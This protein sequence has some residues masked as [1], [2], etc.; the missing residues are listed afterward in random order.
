MFEKIISLENL[1]LAW[2]EFRKG[3]SKKQDIADFEMNL[4]D[5]IFAL[6]KDLASGA[7]KHGKY[8]SFYVCDPKRRHIHK[9]TV[10]DR[11]L[12]R[13]VV[14]VIEPIWERTFIFDSWSCRKDKGHH[15]AIRRFQRFGR[16]LSQNYTKTLWILKLDIR[17]FF[18][19]VNRDVLLKI[20]A[21]KI[22]DERLLSLLR[23]I[24][25]S[26]S[27]GLPLG[28]LTSQ[29]FANIYLDRLDR[30][31]K[32]GL[33][34]RGYIRYADDFIIMHTD[35]DVLRQ[36]LL[37][38]QRFLSEELQ[39]NLH[40]LKIFLKTYSSGI[41]FL[42]YVCFPHFC[43]LRTKTKRRMLV[44]INARNLPSYN[45]VLAHCRSRGLQSLI[46][47]QANFLI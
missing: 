20:V 4:E 31:V 38:I 14:R 44:R 10:R 12:H 22:C 36:C 28:N 34:E 6:H 1:F 43:V 3:K 46:C 29:L 41:D 2:K 47:G 27:P 15:A 18:E 39:L 40:P 17:K 35:K 11:V 19:L 45:G 33:K 8:V 26:F 37:G 5:N 42:G 25:D 21:T 23:E 13:A 7:Y 24:I 32:H 30:F 16:S 9:A